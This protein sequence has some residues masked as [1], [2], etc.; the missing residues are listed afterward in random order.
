MAGLGGVD[1]CPGY[2]W[3][4]IRR[5]IVSITIRML[6][7]GDAYMSEVIRKG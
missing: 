7:D 4:D 1:L 2:H 5:N 6:G 3:Q